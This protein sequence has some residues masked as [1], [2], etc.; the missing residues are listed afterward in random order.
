MRLFLGRKPQRLCD[1]VK[2]V[3]EFGGERGDEEGQAQRGEDAEGQDG[4][5]IFDS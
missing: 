1:M 5:E 4:A 2:A 3:G